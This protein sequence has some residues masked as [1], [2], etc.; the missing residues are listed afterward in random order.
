MGS[1]AIFP[2]F[3]LKMG[4]FLFLFIWVRWTFP[5]FRYDQLMKLGWKVFFHWHFLTYLSQLVTSPQGACLMGIVTKSYEPTFWDKLYFP[6]LVKGLMVTIRYFFKRKV[7]I[8]YPDQKHI[9]PDGYR[10]LHRLNKYDDGR[11][12]VLPVKCVFPRLSCRLH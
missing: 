1:G 10:G 2:V 11:I 3:F 8:Q 12:R 6:A 5:R 9:P 4:F 7:T